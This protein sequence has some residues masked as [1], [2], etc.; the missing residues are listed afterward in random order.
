[1][2]LDDIKKRIVNEIKARAYDDKY[3]DRGEEREIIQIAIQLGVTV[4]SALSVLS[5]VCDEY[6]YVLESRILKQIKDQVE[7]AA[8][9]DGAVDQREF[10]MIFANTRRAMQNKK[11]DREVKRMIVTVMEE[12]GNNK[13]KKGWFS[14]WYATL[15]QELGM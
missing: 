11:T 7:T 6:S 3:I 1:M 4:E 8:G 14:N 13:V 9:N 10:E 5:Q 12:T 15:K 2:E